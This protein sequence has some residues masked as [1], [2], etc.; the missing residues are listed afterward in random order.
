MLVG[1]IIRAILPEIDDLPK[2]V[3]DDLPKSAQH[4][5]F[6]ISVLKKF[7]IVAKQ[8]VSHVHKRAKFEI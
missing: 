5:R 8:Q 4:A 1:S 7:Q 6:S 2:S 3:I